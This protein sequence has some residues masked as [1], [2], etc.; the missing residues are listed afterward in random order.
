MSE[1]EMVLRRR[2]P[3]GQY[4]EFYGF[5]QTARPAATEQ[6]LEILMATLVTVTAEHQHRLI[7]PMLS[8][9]V[10]MGIGKQLGELRA[11]SAFRQALDAMTRVSIPDDAVIPLCKSCGR[12]PAAHDECVDCSH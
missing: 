10:I 8:P 5:M 7:E 11:H 3:D 1:F 2:Q 4:V 6:E 12:N 9:D